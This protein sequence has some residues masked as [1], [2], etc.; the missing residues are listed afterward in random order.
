MDLID[1]I[2]ADWRIALAPAIGAPSFRRLI[3]FVDAERARTDTVIYPPEPDV[4]TALRLTPMASVRAVILGQDPYHGK[5][6]AQGLAFSVP[7]TQWI[8]PSLRNILDEWDADIGGPRPLHG[9]LEP[10][11]HHGVL[12]LNAVLTVNQ[13]RANSHRGKGWEPFTDAIV[14][15]VAA[16]ERPVAFLLWGRAA[17]RK[18]C[19][20]NDRHIVIQA[21]HPSPLSATRG[22]VPFRTSSPFSTANDRLAALGQPP[23]DWSLTDLV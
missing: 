19:L 14:R 13:G 20:I 2:P 8:P 5:G 22:Q 9:S 1:C 15:A 17:Q 6:Q 18:A 4:F 11:A 12:L 7:S 3:E 10:W 16:S 23:I 21:S